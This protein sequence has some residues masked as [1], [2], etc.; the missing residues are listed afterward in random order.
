MCTR[1][2]R[3]QPPARR[4]SKSVAGFQARTKVSETLK[5]AVGTSG[6]YDV[7]NF[8]GNHPP[9]VSC[10]RWRDESTGLYLTTR[11]VNGF[12]P[13][14]RFRLLLGTTRQTRL[15]IAG[16]ILGPYGVPR[17]RYSL[18]TCTRQKRLKI[19]GGTLGPDVRV[20]RSRY[21]LEAAIRQTR[22]MIVGG[23]LG[24]YDVCH[25]RGNRPPH[26]SHNLWRD[27]SSENR[28]PDSTSQSVG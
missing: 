2:G 20:R 16:G 26:A 15:E 27:G 18:K 9:D 1:S 19:A 28:L 8:R 7:S 21:S 6:P 17:S 3:K 22:L 5:I 24:P 23:T 25:F 4:V 13:V 11:R 14:Q 12:G 10:T